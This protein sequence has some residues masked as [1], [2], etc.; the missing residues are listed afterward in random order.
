MGG[1]LESLG[2]HRNAPFTPRKVYVSKLFSKLSLLDE[3]WFQVPMTP[4]SSQWVEKE[5]EGCRFALLT[6]SELF[7]GINSRTRESSICSSLWCSN[8]T[9]IQMKFTLNTG[10]SAIYL[11]MSSV[12]Q[13]DEPRCAL[14]SMLREFDQ[15]SSILFS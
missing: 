15:L 6:D 5:N 3:T 2:R 1:M 8:G 11:S 7:Y 9:Y 13:G 4:H 12:S 14:R 10:D